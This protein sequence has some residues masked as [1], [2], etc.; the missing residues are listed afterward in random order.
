[1]SNATA[2]T[3]QIL[4]RSWYY[5]RVILVGNKNVSKY[6]LYLQIEWIN[7]SIFNMHF[8]HYD[9]KTELVL[10]SWN[11]KL[12]SSSKSLMSKIFQ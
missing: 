4:S 7:N 12:F 2:G 3:A 8:Q 11:S 5:S 9:P 10:S 6:H 1:M